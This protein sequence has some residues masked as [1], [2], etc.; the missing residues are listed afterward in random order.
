MRWKI[1]YIDGTTFSNIDGNPEDAPGGSVQA[2]AQ[3]D[4]VIG[5]AIHH[6]SD[7]YIWDKQYGGWYG[8]DHFGF[9]QYLIRPGKKVIKLAESMTTT[10]YRKLLD[11]IRKDPQ[12][13]KKS[14]SYPWE[15]HI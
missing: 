13:P 14:A 3:E 4:E 2:I 5:S 6:G 9:V 1:F 11:I 12:L 15:I 8:M 7:F 10:G